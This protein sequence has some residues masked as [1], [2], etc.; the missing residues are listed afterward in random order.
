MGHPNPIQTD[1][2]STISIG[3]G[4]D[5]VSSLRIGERGL[6]VSPVTDRVHA[7]GLTMA[8]SGHQ[9]WCTPRR[10]LRVH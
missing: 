5:V 1:R 6:G 2:R 3:C 10:T 7:I 9:T 4:F 8:P